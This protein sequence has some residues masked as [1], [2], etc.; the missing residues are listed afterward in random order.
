MKSVA[1]RFSDNFAP[2]EGT[3]LAHKAIIDEKGYVWYGKLGSV[4]SN[5]TAKDIMDYNSPRIL[6][7]HSGRADRYWA[8]INK[9]QKDTPPL[10]E[11]PEYYRNMASN[12]K[13]WFRV[14]RIER[15]ENNVMQK[16]MVASSGT[17]LSYA[18]KSSMS[19]YFI[20]NIPDSLQ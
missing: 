19:P 2:P 5:K 7:I 20:I 8:Y 10:E 14:I 17:Q 18:S 6:L 3:I 12:F 1:L 16:C 9:V 11:I 4:L 15:A 13:Y